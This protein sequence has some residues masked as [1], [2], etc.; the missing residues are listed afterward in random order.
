MT[1][2]LA[3]AWLANRSKSLVFKIYIYI[4]NFKF[5]CFKLNA[6]M[7]SY[8]QYKSSLLHEF[9]KKKGKGVR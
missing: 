1:S 4:N 2:A 5:F 7:T 9:K 6:V 3:Y 8:V